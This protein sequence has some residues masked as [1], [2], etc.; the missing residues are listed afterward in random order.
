MID[1]SREVLKFWFEELDPKQWF[2]ST[3]E[4]DKEIYKRFGDLHDAAAKGELESWR[5]TP[6]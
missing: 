5:V 1:N 4:L 6:V 2:N 3:E